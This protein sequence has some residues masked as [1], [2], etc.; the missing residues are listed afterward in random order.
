MAFNPCPRM[1]LRKGVKVLA[2]ANIIFGV[3]CVVMLTVFLVLA[4]LQ[5]T[6]DEFK[7]DLKVILIVILTFYF[8]FAIFETGMS[9]F[10]LI[11]T[12]N[13][14]TKRCNIWLVITGII[15]GFAILGPFSQMV[16]GKASYE[17]VWLIGWIPYK[18]YECLVVFSFVKHIN[19]TN[20]E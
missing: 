19:E 11:S 1:P 14:N 7:P 8:L 4:S 17:S 12:N 15:L 2:I 16:F 13:R 10:L 9:V 3:F 20:E 6:D 18:I 5:P